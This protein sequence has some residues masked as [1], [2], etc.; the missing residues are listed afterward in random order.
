MKRKI[1]LCL[2]FSSLLFSCNNQS[3]NDVIYNNGE[4]KL[5]CVLGEFSEKDGVYESKRVN[6]IYL[7]DDEFKEGSYL[8]YLKSNS[9]LL[10]NGFIIN[11]KD[12]LNYTF[13][14][15]DIYNNFIIKEISDNNKIILKEIK[16]DEDIKNDEIRF[17]II[18]ENN[19]VQVYI[20]DEF[21]VESIL[22]HNEYNKYGLFGGSKYTTFE[23]YEKLD[24]NV[25]L[26]SSDYYINRYGSFINE[27]SNFISSKNNSIYENRSN[28]FNN[29]TIEC[30]II[31]NGDNTDNGII[32]NISNDTNK[33]KY[34]ESEVSYYYFFISQSGS[35]SL[36]KVNNG[37]WS[38]LANNNITNYNNKGSYNL[39][40][41][42][43]NSEIYC[44]INNKLFINYND[45]NYLTGNKFAIRS[46]GN[47]I[48][49][50]NIK[51]TSI[52]N[53][54][55]YSLVNVTSGE[56]K[57]IEDFAISKVNN[58]LLTYNNISFNEGTLK[59]NL[60][61][62]SSNKNGIIFKV[63]DDNLSYY[64]L[65]LTSSNQVGFSK[66]VNG[67]EYKEIKKF[68]PYGRN[69]TTLFNIKIVIDNQDIYCY[70]DNR[71][72]YY[73]HDE[74]I[75]NGH[76]VGLKSC[77]KNTSVFN[78]ETSDEKEIETY[79]YLIF[80]HSY[81]EYW[82]SY[83]EDFKEYESIYDIGMG[84]SNTY[85]WA[86]QYNNEVPMYKAHFGIYWNGINDISA[87]F[88]ASFI[89]DNVEKLLTEIKNKNSNFEVVLLGVNRCPFA[90]NYRNKI[91][92]VNTLYKELSNKYDFIHY[93]DTELLYCDSN[94][95]ELSKYF[96]DGLHP[97]NE[98]YK[99]V[100]KLIKETLNKVNKE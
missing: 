60:I 68:L 38:T 66:V 22:N 5:D 19:Y 7:F 57:I 39:K 78:L 96:S 90:I 25:Y 14:G 3:N 46:N 35:A 86:Y 95:N 75:I 48:V 81:T 76:K 50:K 2:L 40:V 72:T 28:K 8:M 20:N 61:A 88:D 74:N 55:D 41:I 12:T 23:G 71:L 24:N 52:I 65:Y 42:K 100:A 30:N 45:L 9:S 26:N 64:W 4:K 33:L 77:G 17:G 92:E 10:E 44:F 59:A 56:A 11:Y 79:E 47:K 1:G 85:E 97:N 21:L 31:L 58:T 69:E 18:K 15:L 73:I 70:F 16:L 13:I 89:K 94:G 98:G 34:W 27:D 83:K 84:A 37:S 99:I 82:Y 62:G 53:S 91:S 54:N 6:S 80:G 87:G 32:F 49:F 67:V 63:S 51:S 36:G 43:D 93:I 29:G